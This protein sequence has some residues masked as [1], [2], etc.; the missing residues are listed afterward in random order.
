MTYAQKSFLKYFGQKW[1]KIQK[2]ILGCSLHIDPLKKRKF[3]KKFGAK[4]FFLEMIFFTGHL[5]DL[6]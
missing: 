5:P 2:K 3:F 1:A 6:I 4:I